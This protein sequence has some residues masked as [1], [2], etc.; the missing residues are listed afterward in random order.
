MGD[1]TVML[2][3]ERNPRRDFPSGQCGACD[4]LR[5]LRLLRRPLDLLRRPLDL[6][7]PPLDLLR[8]AGDE[9]SPIG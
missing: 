4:L 1:I 7:R 6:L 3:E 8:R 9:M 2:P 5:R